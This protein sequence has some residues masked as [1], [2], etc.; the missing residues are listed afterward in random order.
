MGRILVTGGC[1][2]I[3]S[4]TIVDLLEHDYEVVS[5]DNFV[6][7]NPSIL[8]GVEAITGKSVLNIEVDIA[9]AESIGCV[10]EHMK[11][12]DGII[13]FA[14][15][16][17]VPESVEHPNMYYRNNIFSLINMLELAKT[18]DIRNFVFSSSCSVYG[19]VEQLPVT[20]DTPLAEPECAYA[21]TKM[22]GE[23]IV[24]DFVRANPNIKATLLRYFNPV[25]AHPSA[26]IGEMP[27]D[28]PNNLVPYITQTA[29]GI[30]EQLTVFGDDYNTR[31]GS[32]IRDYVHVMD[33]ARAHTKAV[34]YMM[35]N[36]SE[37]AVEVFNLGT[38][39][40]VSVLEAI[41]AFEEVSG[42]K[43]NY[44]I[45]PRRSGDVE[46]VYADNTK[47]TQKLGWKLKYS[48]N[49]MMQSAWDWQKKL[50]G[51]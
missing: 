5:F 25:G 45:G 2:Y 22:M 29:A 1:G 35:N 50:G 24:K 18:N 30:R 15:F 28:V 34:Q 39:N 38:G 9:D 42:L 33:I 4:H 12:I 7:S 11:G 40:G 14:A 44:K 6:R 36:K 21:A 26:V 49:D 31:D 32:C 47:A 46:A 19:N 20:E 37:E 8:K 23:I 41:N 27:V 10:S 17:T 13:H 43:L 51:I 3:G 16:K 48:L